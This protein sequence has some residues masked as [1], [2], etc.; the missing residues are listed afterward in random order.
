MLY[1]VVTADDDVVLYGTALVEAIHAHRH[2][3]WTDL[4]VPR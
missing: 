2:M 3:F 4:T 1:T